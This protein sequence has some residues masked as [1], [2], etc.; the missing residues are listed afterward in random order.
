[1]TLYQQAQVA[2][3]PALGRALVDV[4]RWRGAALHACE[5]AA[6][7]QIAFKLLQA[8][9]R[10]SRWE[11]REDAQPRRLLPDGGALASLLLVPWLHPSVP[12]MI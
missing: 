1:M 6:Q 2:D 10:C 8:L 5:K 7:W 9:K 12:D 4:D 11:P 3:L